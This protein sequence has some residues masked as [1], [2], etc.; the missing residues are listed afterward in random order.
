MC[1]VEVKNMEAEVAIPANSVQTP[2]LRIDD[3][4]HLVQEL[5]HLWGHLLQELFHVFKLVDEVRDARLVAEH[6]QLEELVSG[7]RVLEVETLP[8]ET[9]VALCSQIVKAELVFL[10]ELLLLV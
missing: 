8:Q 2:C 10:F 6:G 9:L 3:G 7:T 5:P 1:R 4:A